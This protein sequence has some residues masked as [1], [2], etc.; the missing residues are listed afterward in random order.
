MR[1][2]TLVAAVVLSTL[3]LTLASGRAQPAPDGHVVVITLDGLRWQEMFGGADRDYFKK[4]KPGEVNP[5][6]TRF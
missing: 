1:A 5:A 3:T 2:R 6:E 4:G